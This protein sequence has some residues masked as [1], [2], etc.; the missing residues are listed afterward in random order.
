MELKDI[1]SLWDRF[2]QSAASVMELDFQ[3]VHFC[4]KREAAAA[5]P[6]TTM[7]PVTAPAASPVQTPMTTTE[8]QKAAEAKKEIKAPLVGIFYQAS[9]PGEKPFV[10][11]GQ[12]VSKGDVVGII[13]AMK[14]MNEI[15]AQ[16]D[17]IVE[18]ILVSDATMVEYDQVLFTL[19]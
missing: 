14:V 2:D 18:E 10:E 4:L 9:A 11:V 3:G 1:Y 12:K 7:V 8:S 19:K 13:E 15:T 6:I 5:A 17:G 16:E